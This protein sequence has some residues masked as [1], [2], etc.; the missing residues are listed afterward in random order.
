[1][2]ID[3]VTVENYKVFLDPQTIE[4]APGFNL[5]VGSNNAGKTTV[6]DVL[7][8]TNGLN[9]PHRSVR[10]VPRYGGT[11]APMSQFEVA[12]STRYEEFRQ[13]GEWN[14]IYLPIAQEALQDPARA[15]SSIREFVKLNSEFAMRTTFGGGVYKLEI[16]A[17]D[18][19]NGTFD[20]S[21][22]NP[23]ASAR[24]QYE[25]PWAEPSVLI[26]G[27]SA[28]HQWAQSYMSAYAR[29]IYRFA[30]QR[31]PGTEMMDQG[32]GVLDR[33]ATRLPFC[34]NHLATN[35]SYGHKTLCQLINRI[36]PSVKWV[37]AP[38]TGGSFRLR[39]LPCE[40]SARRDDL[41]IPIAKMGT[42]LGNVIAMLYVALTT[43]EPQV[44]VI[45]EPNAFL[46]PKALRELLA[47]LESEG[48]QHQ[49]IMTAHS[50]DVITAVNLASI[51][52]LDFDGT[53]TK[54]KQVNKNNLFALRGHLADLGIRITDLHSRD[55]VLWVEGQ[56]E[57][58]VMPDLLRYACPEI[59]AS[60]AVLRVERTGTFS[61]KGVEPSEVANLY[62][63]LS[64]SSAFVPPMVCIVLDAEQRP[65]AERERITADSKGTLRFLPR[66]MLECYVLD[67]D[68]IAAQ[69][70]ALGLETSGSLVEKALT[71]QLGADLTG[72][73]LSDVDA[74]NVLKNLF[75]AMSD[76][77]IEFKKTRDVPSLVAWLVRHKAEQL[78]ELRSFL[79]EV[80]KV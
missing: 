28:Q 35:D 71:D 38:P 31:K 42:G 8:L 2:R 9:D 19:V 14:L 22:H 68:A 7:D 55:R 63:R 1:M 76:T 64:E 80:F 69:L 67:A 15:E 16:N 73:K 77:K 57:E 26:G 4:F 46:H 74:A 18:I 59:A 25:T 47:I 24:L 6:L 29:R 53:S 37:E 30:A 34:I 79:R 62:S 36:F 43:R 50:P 52:M 48:S 45:D 72:E 5:L 20:V 3:S 41:A 32:N 17:D 40:P 44:I 11:T 58:L 78:V 56:T 49:Y 21:N 75:S 65:R 66:R 10:T 60:T 54:A 39:C 61:R 51:V 12:I 13:F 70:T 27:P 23:I 33:E